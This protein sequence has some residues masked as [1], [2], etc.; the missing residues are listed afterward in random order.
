[1]VVVAILL[2]LKLPS[3][4]RAL[5]RNG[6]KGGREG[7]REEGREGE[8]KKGGLCLYRHASSYY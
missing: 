1:M 8:S 7:G 3:A 4:S 6:K 2:Q 5:G